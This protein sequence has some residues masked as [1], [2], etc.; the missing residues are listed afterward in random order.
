MP[1]TINGF[2]ILA[3]FV[4]TEHGFN[5]A[6]RIILVDG[7]AGYE[8]RYVVAWQGEGDGW[9]NDSWYCVTR[10]DAMAAFVDRALREPEV[11]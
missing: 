2:P 4:A 3:T 10:G 11:R 5:R 6:G 8:E 1:D 9:W 7:G